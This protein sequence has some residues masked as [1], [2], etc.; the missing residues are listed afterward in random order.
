LEE[1]HLGL[2]DMKEFFSGLW[3]VIL[4]LIRFIWWLFK[5]VFLLLKRWC[6]GGIKS[7][8][9]PNGYIAIAT[10]IGA[11]VGVYSII[12]ARYDRKMN[13]ATFERGTFITMVSSG[14]RGSFVAAMK[15]FG[16]LQNMTV[17]QEPE[18]LNFWTWIGEHQ[19]NRWPLWI[20]AVQYLSDCDLK[21][22]GW[23][24][25]VG[26]R[27]FRIDLRDA[28]LHRADLG[29]VNLRGADLSWAN[30]RGA[31]LGIA[32][33]TGGDLRAKLHR[34]LGADLM[35]TALI[36]ADPDIRADLIKAKLIRMLGLVKTDLRE[37]DLSGADLR[38]ADLGMADLRGAD[39]IGADF[40]SADLAA[41]DL[42]GADLRKANLT[43]A[44]NLR[45]SQVKS[46][47][48]W[49]LAFYSED[50]LKELHLPPD[51]NETLPKRILEHEMEEIQKRLRSTE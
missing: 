32:D 27:Q 38:G 50:I 9:G 51:H 39:L 29:G 22:C 46:A 48:N 19:P 16:P 34:A 8:V 14:H 11:Y 43:R 26:D 30:M 23:Q 20:W 35:G 1:K 5:P 3:K 6:I 12:E 45:A 44:K 28:D 10:L 18:L 36:R 21:K 40:Y 13:R 25:Q 24:S 42:T 4:A 41:A 49:D 37:A 47:R 15:K 7:F 2:L 31:D 33:L 17:P